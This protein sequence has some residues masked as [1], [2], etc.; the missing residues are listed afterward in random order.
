MSPGRFAEVYWWPMATYMVEGL[1]LPST[2]RLVTRC[3][4][5]SVMG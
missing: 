1:V 5:E 3:A 2:R 4:L